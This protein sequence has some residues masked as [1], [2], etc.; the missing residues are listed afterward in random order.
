MSTSFEASLRELAAGAS[1]AHAS[2]TAG[3][4]GL[5]VGR[6]A[7]RVR[8]RRV[9]KAAAGAAAS[10]TAV[11]A[12]VLGGVV[13]RHAPHDS[14]APVASQPQEKGAIVQ[15][16]EIVHSGPPAWLILALV[17]FAATALYCGVRL[18]RARL[19][20]S[21]SE[22][23]RR[24]RIIRLVAG[25]SVLGL[26]ISGA[27]LLNSAQDVDLEKTQT[28]LEQHYGLTFSGSITRHQ[29]DGGVSVVQFVLDEP[30]ASRTSGTFGVGALRREGNR[31]SLLQLAPGSGKT[32]P[33]DSQVA[34]LTGAI[35]EMIRNG[36]LSGLVEMP[37]K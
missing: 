2:R 9:T 28:A 23:A 27:A 29:V 14:S 35:S 34:D 6:I 15:G 37:A 16:I 3:G 33:S 36:S 13:L 18:V 24:L 21:R 30:A 19:S 5:P 31:V 8:R 11:T 32:A 25:A 1:T 26:V 22:P 10:V 17:I 4:A 12:L 7:A 20:E